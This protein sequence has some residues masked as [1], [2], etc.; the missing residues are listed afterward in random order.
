VLSIAGITRLRT[1]AFILDDLPKTDPVYADLKFFENNFKGV[2]PLEIL[3]DTRRK[4]GIRANM[5]GNF[6]KIDKLSSYIDS[7]S[8]MARPLS[9]VEGLKFVRQAYYDNDS[10]NYGLPNE[11]D[12]S[13]LSPYLSMK[14]DSNSKPSGV[15]KLANSFVD[16]NK[17]ILRI[18][19]NMADVG[20][21]RLPQILGE[22][23]NRA[24]EL[25][26]TAH[27]RI[28]YRAD[29][30][31]DDK[32]GAE[33]VQ[34]IGAQDKVP[35]DL[36]LDAQVRLLH[37]RVLQSIVDDVYPAGAGAGKNESRKR[38]RDGRRKRRKLTRVRID[39]KDVAR[40]RGRQHGLWFSG[41][42]RRGAK[43]A[44]GPDQANR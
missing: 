3:I 8:V 23:K 24:D 18:S 26:D 44:Q 43:Q 42:R 20:S 29:R 1:E 5:L 2:M 19:V 15:M 9:I 40:A 16:S 39:E 31:A 36:A 12:I 6:T 14:P 27:Y 21:I 33:V 30:P 7:S 11:F 34:V 4:N 22:V 17:Q 35:S 25:F 13:F 32:V 38:I 10:L 28:E 41:P 37:H